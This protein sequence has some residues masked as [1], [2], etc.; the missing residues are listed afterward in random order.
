[1]ESNF[2]KERVVVREQIIKKNLAKE[3]ED[4]KKANTEQRPSTS[5]SYSTE[6]PPE[7]VVV[8]EELVNENLKQDLVNVSKQ[9][10]AICQ[11]IADY[12]KVKATLKIFKTNPRDV[13]VKTNIGCNFYAQCQIEDA[14]K[15][16]VCLGSD[17]YLLMDLDEAIKMVEFKEKQWTQQLDLL[18]EKASKI[19]AHIKIA[20]EALG[21]VYEIDREKL[22]SSE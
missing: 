10:D 4:R 19:K 13:R 7:R 8:L 5:A 1:M 14:S 18:Q 3:K 20:L 16:Y 2:I 21:R 15:V 11:T 22:T 12:L 6:N 9:V 17:Y